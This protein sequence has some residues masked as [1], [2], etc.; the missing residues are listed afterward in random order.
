VLH[1]LFR[2][3]TIPAKVA[4]HP[5][6]VFGPLKKKTRTMN[7]EEKVIRVKLGVLSGRVDAN[8]SGEAIVAGRPSC[9]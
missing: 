5:G 8:E 7:Q 3:P 2:L 6:K 9:L 1:G 4:T